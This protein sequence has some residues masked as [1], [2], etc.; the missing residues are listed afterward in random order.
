[1]KNNQNKQ[2]DLGIFYTSPSVVNFIFDILNI[3]KNKDDKETGRWLT[4]KPLHYPSIIDPA[5]GEGIFLKKALEKKFTKPDWIFGLDIDEEIVKKWP[6]INLLNEFN[7]NKEKLYSHFFHQDG[8]DKIHWEQH[9]PEYYG[10]L[11]KE[12]INKEQFDTVVGN[13]PYGGIGIQENQLKDSVIENLSQFNL[14]TKEVKK[15][16]N[17]TQEGLFQEQKQNSL[18][19]EFKNRLKSFPI[20]I[21]F[22]EK[23][24]RLT[25]P[26][27][28]IAVII[29][30]GILANSSLHYVRE[31]IVEKTVV[32][33]II[34]LPR[35]TFKEAGTNAKTSILILKKK[36]EKDN[37]LNYPVFLSNMEKLSQDIFDT[38]INSFK[39]FYY[40]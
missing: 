3:L 5:C 13:P 20:E 36:K 26:N 29:P 11:K 21:L 8:L 31:F 14:I 33:A 2:K 6:E 35:G 34:S 30:D 27:G 7:G 38:I 1:M 4:R 10:K 25:K 15:E 19:K 24:I 9:K 28:W 39:K 22:L 40:D 32:I 12:D 17:S 23:F 16:L 37:N 18:K